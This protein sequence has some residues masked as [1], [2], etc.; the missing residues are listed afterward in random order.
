MKRTAYIFTILILS[1]CHMRNTWE[2][3]GNCYNGEGTK[4]WKDGGIEK[5]TWENGELIGQG[6]QFFG[7]T[8]DFAGDSYEGEFLNGYYGYGKYIDV[9]EDATYIGYW[10]NG[11]ADGNG[12]LTFGQNS[13]YPNRYYEGEW[14][15]GQRHGYGVKFWG[16]AG[17][18]TNNRY[19]G[20]WK[21]DEMDGIGRY[22]WP[23]KGTYIGPWKNGEQHGEGIYISQRR[24]AK[25]S[26]V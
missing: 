7:K 19:E 21:D 8:S 4:K 12:K 17:D 22:D 2:C 23:D 25:K 3:E 20:K 6:Y 14:Q 13:E 15:N 16:E 18:Y 10:K 1:S 26:L 24:Y 11:K 9:S 5:G